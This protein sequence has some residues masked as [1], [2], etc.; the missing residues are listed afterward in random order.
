MLGSPASARERRL[1]QIRLDHLQSIRRELSLHHLRSRDPRE[2]G[3]APGRPLPASLE[4]LRDLTLDR[5]LIIHDPQSGQPYGYEVLGAHRFR[6]GADFARPAPATT[7]P[8]WRHPAG[9]SWFEF[10][11]DRD[12]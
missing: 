5:A 9:P 11:L 10:D 1:D 6:I 7:E 2:T 3:S 4:E 12:P 8:R